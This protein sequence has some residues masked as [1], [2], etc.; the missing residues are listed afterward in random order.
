WGREIAKRDEQGRDLVLVIDFS[1]SMQTEDMAND[2][3]P[4]D[5][6]RAV[7]QAATDF[8]DQRQGD[9]IGVIAFAEQAFTLSPLTH[10]HAALARSLSDQEA[11]QRRM[12][13]RTNGRRGLYGSGTAIG[14]GLGRALQRLEERNENGRAVILI[15]DGEESENRVPPLEAAAQAAAMD[16]RVHTIGV[17][18][19]GGRI[20][21]LRVG[22]PDMATLRRIATTTG[23]SVAR[24]TESDELAAIFAEINTL[25]PSPFTMSVIEDYHD[26]FLWP[27]LAGMALVLLAWL[28]EPRLRGAP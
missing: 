18:G 3:G 1:G 27:L 2:S 17:G 15:T 12:W 8:I 14:L 4:D 20:G 5:R 23:G 25:E 19:S 26:R 22:K 13:R 9:R 28:S 16:I 7:I 10:D 11:L 24:A 6:L 21:R